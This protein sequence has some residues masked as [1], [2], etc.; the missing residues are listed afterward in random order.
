MFKQLVALLCITTF[1]GFPAFAEVNGASKTYSLPRPE[2][3]EIIVKALKKNDFDITR[4]PLGMGRVGLRAV[5]PK[6]TWQLTL[7]PNSALA[8]DVHATFQGK[9]EKVETPPGGDFWNLISGHLSQDANF[10]EPTEHRDYA[11]PIPSVILSKIEAVV[12]IKAEKQPNGMQLSGFVVDRQGLIMCTAH[13][14]SNLQ[15]VD[16][17]CHDGRKFRGNVIQ[18]DHELDLALIHIDRTFDT[19][20]DITEGRNLLGVGELLYSVGCPIDLGGTIYRGVINGPPRHV[21][22]LPLWQVSME[23]HEGSSGSPVFDTQGT[24]VAIVKGR[25]RGT[26]SIGFLIPLET[27]M[28]FAA[29]T[30]P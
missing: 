11:Q 21:N 18:T 13:D 8:T 24:V 25:Y 4:R 23:I 29:S 3:E 19:F 22:G 28:K 10:A 5:T 9:N 12:C 7:T 20:I 16:V 15:A 1:F 30:D 2:V 17:I 6:G 26:D 27:V 14:L